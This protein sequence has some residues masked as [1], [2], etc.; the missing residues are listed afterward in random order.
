MKCEINNKLCD[1]LAPLVRILRSVYMS[2]YDVCVQN[3]S[4]TVFG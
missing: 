3:I 4:V 2:T 1:G